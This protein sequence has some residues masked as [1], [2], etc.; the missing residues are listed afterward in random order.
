[1]VE[2][3][4]ITVKIHR[5][6]FHLGSKMREYF[7]RNK[8]EFVITVIVII[9]FDRTLNVMT[10]SSKLVLVEHKP[11]VLVYKSTRV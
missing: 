10:V 11:Y 5:I 3:S 7:V 6:K 4:I 2:N 8:R 1:M 9:K